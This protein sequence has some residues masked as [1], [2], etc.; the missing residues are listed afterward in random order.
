MISQ[1]E[2]C[3]LLTESYQKL[4]KLILGNDF[5]WY[6]YS[7]S[8]YNGYYH[9]CFLRRPDPNIDRRRVLN[10][11]TFF[12]R[13]GEELVVS[14]NASDYSSGDIVLDLKCQPF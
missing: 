4:K 8:T 11:Q 13:Y 5:P 14:K 1:I 10:L 3:E 2:R 7:N 12:S 6:W 9:H